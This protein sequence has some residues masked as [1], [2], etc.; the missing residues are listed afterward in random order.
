MP[1]SASIAL[2]IGAVGSLLKFI[3]T[4]Q[5]HWFV[6]SLVI[7]SLAMT[8]HLWEATVA[9]PMLV[10][11]LLEKE[12]KK[13]AV[14]STWVLIIA[15]GIYFLAGL[16]PKAP[17]TLYGYSTFAAGFDI[18]LSP[19]WWLQRLGLNPFYLSIMI[20]TPL[21]IGIVLWFGY[22]GIRT[23]DRTD[24]VISAWCLSGLTIPLLI[25]RGFSIHYYYIWGL[26]APISLAA[27]AE[28]NRVIRT[29]DVS[30]FL[31]SVSVRPTSVIVSV[32]ILSALFYGALFE[33]GAIQMVPGEQ[34]QSA[35]VPTS[36]IEEIEGS[37]PI[38][39]GKQIREMGVENSS[40]IIFVGNWT[41]KYGQ[42]ALTRTLI[43][44]GV[45]ITER[46]FNQP[47]GP[48]VVRNESDIPD[49]C[50]VQIHKRDGIQVTSC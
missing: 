20:S 33:V 30:R 45:G 13:A 23:Q 6:V 34:F 39:A 25:A 42:N 29:Y 10:L 32:L 17:S 28:L 3:Q 31:P 22:R 15:V 41:R 44:A 48:V 12:W 40:K 46:K 38:A 27:T 18:L 36:D 4:D 21:A 24:I 19:D 2:T 47:G 8:N 14:L 11:L 5:T 16:G 1:E 50:V 43:Y 7:L 49:E 37:E 26:T 35:S 9:L